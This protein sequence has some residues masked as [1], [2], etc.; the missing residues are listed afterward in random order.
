MK[1]KALLLVGI[2]IIA[3]TFSTVLVACNP[4]KMENIVGTYKLVVDTRTQYEQETVDNIATYGREAYIVLTGEDYG[5]YIYKDNYFAQSTQLEHLTCMFFPKNGGTYNTVNGFSA[6]VY[7]GYYL[8][9]QGE[10]TVEDMGGGLTALH[11]RDGNSSFVSKTQFATI[12]GDEYVLIVSYPK[13]EYD[14]NVA[15]NVISVVL[16][17]LLL[18]GMTVAVCVFF[19]KRFLRPLLKGIEQIQ[20]QEHKNAESE[21][22]EID[23]LFAFLAEQDRIKDEETE[24]LRTQCNEQGFSLE[25]KQADIDRLAY[26]RKNEVS[27]DDYEMF[28]TGLKTLTKTEKQ[29]F[30]LYLE[31]KSANEIMEICHIQQGTLKYHNHNILGKLGVSS[32]KQMLRYATLLKQ[33]TQSK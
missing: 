28:K 13:E 12:C 9:P 15:N 24:K 11:S 6:G 3:L 30:G 2:L 33:E 29:I 14:I 20:K 16:L 4:D 21:F 10:L 7:G 1:K 19:S 23:D 18:V 25:Q 31:G 32:R 5:Y 26:S 17:V 22:V 8:P 27:P